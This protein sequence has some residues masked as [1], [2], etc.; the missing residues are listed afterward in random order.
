M[1]VSRGKLISLAFLSIAALVSFYMWRDL[2]LSDDTGASQAPKVIVET[3]NFQR[4]ISGEKWIVGIERAERIDGIITGES[5]D[6]R[7]E[8]KKRTMSASAASGE[9]GEDILDLRLMSVKGLMKRDTVSVDWS[10]GRVDYNRSSD[11]WVF[12]GGIT[13]DDGSVKIKGNYGLIDSKGLF[14]IKKGA[15][16]RWANSK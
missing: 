15:S 2:S 8:G 12:P 1:R 14:H 3:L 10:A 6:I 9:L 11:A 13:L 7:A 16:V 5:I 4:V